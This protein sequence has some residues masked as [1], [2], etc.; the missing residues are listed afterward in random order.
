MTDDCDSLCQWNDLNWA[1]SALNHAK[2]NQNK[3]LRVIRDLLYDKPKNE[4]DKKTVWLFV[5]C[6]HSV[7]LQW[8]RW[9]PRKNSFSF[10]KLIIISVFSRFLKWGL[11]FT[12]N[13]LCYKIW[14]ILFFLSNSPLFLSEKLTCYI[15]EIT[16]SNWRLKFFADH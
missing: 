9:V 16:C 1:N 14:H 11:N 7:W 10:V 3:R 4:I 2:H 5:E 8:I 15:A 13:I 12:W 6:S